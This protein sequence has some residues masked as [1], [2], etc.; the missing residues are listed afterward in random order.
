M[1]EMK[2]SGISW[3]NEIPENWNIEPIKY[4]YSLI[5]GATPESTNVDFWD[6]DIKWITPA[7]FKT[8][9]IFVTGGSRNL[10]IEG[11][12]SC[13]TSM[14]PIG[15]IV[16]SKRAPIGTVAITADK[17]CINQGCLGLVEKSGRV[18]NKFYFYVISI[19][20]DVFNLYGSG[21]TFK[22]I[23]ANVFANI[24]LPTPPIQ[25]Q[26]R[27]ADFLDTKCAEIDV[28]TTD[29]QTQIYILE[30]YKRS[31]ITETVTK[32]LN[33]NAEMKASG[34][35]W[36]GDMPAHWDVIRGKYI[37][38]YMQKPVREDDGVITCFRDGEVTLRS[39]RREDGFTM[40]DKEIGYQG[41]DVGDLVVHGMDGFAGSIGI[42]DS[43]GK[44]SPVLNVLDT[45]KCKR[46]IMYYLRS[47]AYSD[48][49]LALATGIRVRSCDL[50][51]NKLAELSYPIPPLDEQ[52]A[53]VEHIDSVLSK[54]DAVIV[55]KKAQLAT[56]DEYKKSL[57]FEYVTGKKEVV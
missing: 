48:V 1:R 7:D 13:S 39:N 33:P 26:K 3:I 37:L 45:D 11:Y 54:A 14:L 12:K 4:N 15:S 40:S 57:I 30:Q 18:L 53:I 27:I 23:S 46:Y 49:F 47:M 6:G 32:G 52:N 43:R 25:E 19:Y 9:D 38:R 41:I 29:I 24:K 31:V 5:A 44:A 21:T 55:D 51:W 28:L 34:I 16:F 36:I 35:Q 10:T 56:L 42:S 8:K 2:D 20:S 50:R 22:E 17:L